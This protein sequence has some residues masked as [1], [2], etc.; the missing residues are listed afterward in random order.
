MAW[1]SECDKLLKVFARL[2]RKKVSVS[3][4]FPTVV[5]IQTKSVILLCPCWGIHHPPMHTTKNCGRSCK[6]I[7][8]YHWCLKAKEGSSLLICRGKRAHPVGTLAG[9]ESYSGFRLC[10][11]QWSP[12]CSGTRWL[13][14]QAN[15]SLSLWPVETI[16]QDKSFS[17][18]LRSLMESKHLNSVRTCELNLLLVCACCL[19]TGSHGKRT[20]GCDVW[21]HIKWGSPLLVLCQHYVCPDSKYLHFQRFCFLKRAR[22]WFQII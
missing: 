14:L 7:L 5:Y 13:P 21:L 10:L 18:H 11:Q 8:L 17:N 1:S 4:I 3:L 9:V 19:R 6:S 2:Q 20:H 15:D 12:L 22:F 16:G